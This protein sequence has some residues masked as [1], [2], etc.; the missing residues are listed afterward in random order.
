MDTVETKGETLILIRERAL[1]S[2]VKVYQNRL[3][4]IDEELESAKAQVGELQERQGDLEK[5]LDLIGN[6][7]K[8]PRVFPL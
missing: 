4:K 1:E 2:I 8:R 6:I 3:F 7:Y 5:A